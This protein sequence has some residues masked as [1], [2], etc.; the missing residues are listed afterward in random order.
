MSIVVL[1]LS[2]PIS[3]SDLTGLRDRID[4]LL[5]D[6]E[7]SHL[8]CDVA[9]VE[10]SAVTVDALAYLHLAALRCGCGVRIRGASG[11]LRELVALVGLAD[12]LTC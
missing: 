12:V 6:D 9:R 11:E 1:T 5:D 10:A 2:G 4:A 3:R 7:A 8:L